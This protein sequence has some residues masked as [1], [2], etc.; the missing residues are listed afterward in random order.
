VACGPSARGRRPRAEAR[1]AAGCVVASAVALLVLAAPAAARATA[2][3]AVARRPEIRFKGSTR[4]SGALTGYPSGNA[5]RPIELEADPY[6]YGSFAVMAS[7]ATA[8]D[9]SYSFRISPRRNTRY[10]VALTGPSSARSAVVGVTVDELVRTRVRYLPLGRARLT[11]YSRHPA[12]LA[13]GGRRTIWYLSPDGR[14]HLQ[15]VRANHAREV[16]PGLTRLR[17]KVAVSAGRFRFAACL[18]ASTTAAMGPPGA[19]APCRGRR[20]RGG[21]RA[22]Y[23]GKGKAPFGYP[24]RRAIARARRYLTR[25]MGVTSFAVTTSE[26]RVYG[27]HVHRRFVSASVVKAMLLVAYLRLLDQRHHGLDPHSR[28]LLGPMIHVSDNGA[29]TAVWSRVGDPRLRRLAR[30]AGMSDF[31]IHGIWANAMISAADQSRFFFEMRSLIPPRFRHYADHLL[32]HIA[33]FESWG[34]PAVA[35]PRHWKVYFKGGWRGT[36][37]GQLVHQAAR[38]ERRG[39]RIAI[40]VMTDGDP[41]MGYGIKTI[42]GV[43]ARLLAGS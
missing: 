28:S 39:E 31:S 33:G 32:S 1:L 4:I 37:R 38:L 5:G 2:I 15:R 14:G 22:L 10:R 43:A 29:A 24:G 34:I 13:W 19:H 21:R 26:G 6:P 27:A 42:E 8:T 16:A 18:K 36:G 17:V 23:Q 12:N 20:F 9:G 41:S 11:A 35:R 3:T 7:G 30:R 40:A 25:R